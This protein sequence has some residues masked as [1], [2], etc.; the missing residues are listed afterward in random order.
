VGIIGK[1]TIVFIRWHKS[2]FYYATA[3]HS[4]PTSA[5]TDIEVFCGVE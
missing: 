1:P 3:S 4:I 2:I 5:A